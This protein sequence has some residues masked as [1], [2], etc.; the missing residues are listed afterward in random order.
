MEDIYCFS[1]VEDEPSAAV[2]RKLVATRNSRKKH[3]L[4]FRDGFPS[5]MRGSGAI[6]SNCE[7][8]L[9]MAKGGIYSFILTDLDSADCA[10]SLIRSWFSIPNKNN[11]ILPSQC[12]FRVAVRE[13]ESWIIADHEAWAEFIG[14]PAENFSTKPDELDD[15]KR[16]LLNVIRRKGRKKIHRE[17]LPSGAAQIGPRY[18][19]IL[20]DFVENAWEPERAAKN[21][22]SLDRAI[23]ALMII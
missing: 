23:K 6:K 12:I 1:Y 14:I 8:F 21:S 11:L 17:M 20:C 9:R 16:H 19:E 22:P 4:V 15:P 2:A 7:A 10:C 5:I 18:N 3:S 13:I